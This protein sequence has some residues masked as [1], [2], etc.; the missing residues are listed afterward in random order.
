M[1]K[2][3]KYTLSML[4]AGAVALS[5]VPGAQAVPITGSL[6]FEDGTVQLNGPINS[7]TEV[8]FTST[9]IVNNAPLVQPTGAF[10]GSGGTTVTFF[11]STITFSPA[12]SPNPVSPL[13]TFNYNGLTYSFSLT[14]ITS[15]VGVGPSL[16]LAGDGIITITGPGST[17]D[18]TVGNWTFS[19]TGS[20]T[21]DYTFGFVA[22]D[23]AVPEAGTTAILLGMGLIGLV[24][25]AQFRKQSVA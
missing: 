14:S 3:T 9:A 16:N 20:G 7:A 21:T 23:S 4:A 8:T 13:W 12:L 15:S 22:G 25:F 5:L 24:G 11:P 1:T 6:N 19:T 18:A 10:A 17:Y 2:T